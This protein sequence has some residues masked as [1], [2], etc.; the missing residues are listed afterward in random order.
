MIY[1]GVCVSRII[2]DLGALFRWLSSATCWAVTPLDASRQGADCWWKNAENDC[3][4]VLVLALSSTGKS[5]R[6]VVFQPAAGGS[7]SA[8]AASARSIPVPSVSFCV[9][10]T[11]L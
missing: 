5:F 1:R 4:P 8:K 2:P 11:L 9:S 10:S 3:A 6:P 7:I